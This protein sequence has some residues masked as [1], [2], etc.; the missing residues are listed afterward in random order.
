MEVQVDIGEPSFCQ[1]DMKT[2]PY[3]T[4]MFILPKHEQSFIKLGSCQQ[5][6]V[7]LTAQI[8]YINQ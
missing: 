4:Q 6:S 2:S 1:V 8:F 7:S 5:A 3:I